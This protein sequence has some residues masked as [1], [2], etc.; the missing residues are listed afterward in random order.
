MRI[1]WLYEARCELEEL[2]AGCRAGE[3]EE[4]AR[5]LAEE[6]LGEVEKLSLAPR[7]GVRRRETLLGRHGFR[8]LLIGAYACIYRVEEDAVRIYHLTDAGKDD[9]YEILGVASRATEREVRA[10]RN[11]VFLKSTL[12]QPVKAAMLLLVTALITFTFVSRVSEYLL[13]REETERLAGFYRAAG[14]LAPLGDFAGDAGEA[15]RYLEADPSVKLVDTIETVSGVVEG[16]LSGGYGRP[17][18]ALDNGTQEVELYPDYKRDD[19]FFY[20]KL[21]AVDRKPGSQGDEYIFYFT[22]DEVLAGHHLLAAG[23]NERVGLANPNEWTTWGWKKDMEQLTISTYVDLTELAG[24]LEVGGRYLL[25]GEAA[26]TSDSRCCDRI[27]YQH[28]PILRFKPLTEDGLWY[29]PVPE[30]GADF[31]DPALAGVEEEIGLYRDNTGAVAVHLVEDMSL[32]T[33]TWWK[34]A[35]TYLV[36]GRWLNGQDD[37]SGNKVCVVWENMG[38]H[39][40]DKVTID[41][42]DLDYPYNGG[43]LYRASDLARLGEIETSGPVEYEVVGVINATKREYALYLWD[44]FLPHSA[45]PDTFTHG[46]LPVRAHEVL[47]ELTGPDAATAFIAAAREPLGQLGVQAALPETG[48]ADFQAAAQPMRRSSLYNALIFT[49]VLL[50]AVCL[51]VFLYFRMRRKDVAIA[52]AMGVPVGRCV[53]DVSVP[54]LLIGLLGIG[55]GGGLGWRYTL[56]NAGETLA[57]LSE[58]GGET[59]AALPGFWLAALWGAVLALLAAVTL[60]GALALSRRPVL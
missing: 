58:F 45:K 4:A 15:V 50:S 24:E 8:A 56:D 35:E 10:M 5:A 12:R 46:D 49:G 41:L 57:A 40:G 3:G 55:A 51:I 53:W 59:A 54:L 34:N 2:L 44:F 18:V 27:P 31:S 30:D 20:G 37:A 21:T 11:N 32:M 22:V 1:E 33:S 6:I 28:G 9:L 7:M 52:R 13:V 38:L 39:A 23:E 26:V 48:W 42:R 16:R 19:A 17:A 14:A 36:E 29:Y 43:L 60:G 47:F 25:R